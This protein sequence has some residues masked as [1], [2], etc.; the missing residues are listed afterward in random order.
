MRVKVMGSVPKCC[1]LAVQDGEERA[2]GRIPVTWTGQRPAGEEGG[3]RQS[4]RFGHCKE[5]EGASIAA[6]MVTMIGPGGG[7]VY[8]SRSGAEGGTVTR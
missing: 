2:S 8:R 4:R 7:F 1:R 6:S 5:L 3:P